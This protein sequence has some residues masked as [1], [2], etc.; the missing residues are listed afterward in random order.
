MNSLKEFVKSRVITLLKNLKELSKEKYNAFNEDKNENIK[1]PLNKCNYENIGIYISN[2][3]E[4][5]N[6]CKQRF[7]L[8]DFVSKNTTKY[9]VFDGSSKGDYTLNN[10]FD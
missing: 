6:N 5:K 8:N 2:P 10:K 3:A 1:I 9:W 7:T 4:G